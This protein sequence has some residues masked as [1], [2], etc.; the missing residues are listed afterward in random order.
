MTSFWDHLYQYAQ[1]HLVVRYLQEEPTGYGRLSIQTDAR[2]RGLEDLL[3]GPAARSFRRLWEEQQELHSLEEQAL[4]R[5]G[6]PWAW[7]WAAGSGTWS[8]PASRPPAGPLG[9]G[10]PPHSA[11]SPNRDQ[12]L[13]SVIRTCRNWPISSAGPSSRTSRLPGV[14]G[15]QGI[16]GVPAVPVD[17]AAQGLPHIGRVLLRGDLVLEV[18]QA[19]EVGL[20]LL[21]GHGVVHLGGGGPHPGGEDKGEQGVEPHLL[22][23]GQG[24]LKLLRGLPGKA[25]DHVGGEHD[26]RDELLQPP[27]PRP[28]I[29]PGS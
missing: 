2:R 1:E 25:H 7:P 8:S 10:L 18:H 23:Q 5:A 4:F 12:V 22:Q 24:L 28:G 29:A 9:R 16:P 6:C 15:G 27:A 19:L 20:L 13:A 14:R 3:R 26:V 11:S 21:V 17:Q